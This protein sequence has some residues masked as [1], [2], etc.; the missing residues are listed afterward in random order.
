MEVYVTVTS[1]CILLEHQTL[2]RVTE[3]TNWHIGES[4]AHHSLNTYVETSSSC[5]HGGTSNTIKDSVISNQTKLNEASTTTCTR[6]TE[7]EYKGIISHGG[8]VNIEV[9]CQR[10]LGTLINDNLPENC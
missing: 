4:C 7:L 2:R 10:S 6:T 1:A 5:T 8:T 9:I 3:Q